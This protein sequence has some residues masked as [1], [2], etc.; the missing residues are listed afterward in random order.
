MRLTAIS[1]PI[2][3]D[4]VWKLQDRWVPGDDERP[5]G[6][7]VG[8]DRLLTRQRLCNVGQADADCPAL[9]HAPN[10]RRPSLK[11]IREL[12]KMRSADTIT[13]E[14]SP[15]DGP[16]PT[17]AQ[18]GSLSMASVTSSTDSSA[19]S[20]ALSSLDGD[21][22]ALP[23]ESIGD[24]LQRQYAA[25]AASGRTPTAVEKRQARRREAMA[26]SDARDDRPLLL[27]L[28]ATFALPPLLI[29][30]VSARGL[31]CGWVA[32]QQRA[33]CRSA[34]AAALPQALQLSPS[35]SSKTP[36]PHSDCL[37][38]RVFGPAVH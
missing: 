13:V 5:S 2:R 6:A 24:R 14:F 25:A 9:Q 32:D 20:S 10:P 29:L 34:R 16:V 28:F 7:A 12:F 26:I 30:G 11:N 37:L 15:W 31:G 4:E 8:R 18:G 35:P 3:R 36:Q 1:D 17:A 38:D 23:G 19:P 22:G 21:G 33:V 27:G